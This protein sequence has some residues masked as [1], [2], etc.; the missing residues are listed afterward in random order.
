[1]VLVLLIITTIGGDHEE[2]KA[3]R[4]FLF[5]LTCM[6]MKVSLALRYILSTYVFYSVQPVCMRAEYAHNS[7]VELH[8][9]VSHSVS[10]FPRLK[11]T[12][13]S[14]ITSSFS[15]GRHRRLALLSSTIL[16][17]PSSWPSSLRCR[18]SVG[19]SS[20]FFWTWYVRCCSP[21]SGRVFRSYK[22]IVQ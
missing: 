14:S 19:F 15:V 17:S 12:H 1:M 4:G 5:T 10:V 20:F 9:L 6:E 18:F 22:V 13:S 11:P 16:T 2:F 7:S 8:I 3:S 21:N